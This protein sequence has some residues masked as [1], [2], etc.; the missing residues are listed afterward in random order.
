MKGKQ[1]AKPMQEIRL[2]YVSITT[3]IPLPIQE[4][5]KRF[6]RRLFDYLA[7]PFPKLKIKRYDGQ[8][9]GD[10]IQL[11]L[12]LWPIFLPWHL[13]I[14]DAWEDEKSWGFTDQATMLPFPL[15]AWRHEHR[16]VAIGPM[17]TSIEDFVGF[18]AGPNW[19]TKLMQPIVHNMFT[20][21]KPAYLRYFC[22]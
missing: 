11:S 1:K 13:V 22:D 14:V 7:P 5:T 21:R 4:V 16:L 8:K 10:V 20:S 2:C 9:K 17:E 6:D 19:L 3:F 15:T 12:G 18:R